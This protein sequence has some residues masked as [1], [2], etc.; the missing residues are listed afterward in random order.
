MSPV[1]RH[2]PAQIYLRMVSTMSHKGND[3]SHQAERGDGENGHRRL[4]QAEH[5]CKPPGR[6]TPPT[7]YYGRKE[8]SR[9]ECGT[10]RIARCA[11]TAAPSAAIDHSSAVRTDR[12]P[13]EVT[14]T[15][16]RTIHRR[17]TFPTFK[18]ARHSDPK[19]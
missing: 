9:V 12:T 19:C 17:A 11:I 16:L 18:K 8:H 10:S 3:H 13:V 1:V 6:Y 7:F 15:T 2:D 14:S 4:H 5:L